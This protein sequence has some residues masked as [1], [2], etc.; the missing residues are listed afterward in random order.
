[1]K[2]LVN[3]IPEPGVIRERLRELTREAIVLRALLK[4]AEKKRALSPQPLVAGGA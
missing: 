4:V 1:M 2:S 3:A